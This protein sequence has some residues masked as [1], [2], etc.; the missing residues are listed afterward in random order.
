MTE[1]HSATP[2]ANDVLDQVAIWIERRDR[3]DWS[4]ADQAALDAWLEQSPAHLVAFLRSDNAW[5]RAD[6]LSALR[7]FPRND[8]P[9]DAGWKMM[10]TGRR[11]AALMAVLG[12]IG[13]AALTYTM[14]SS[15]QVYSTPV[16]GHTVLS[17]ADGSKI[18]LNTDTVLRVRNSGTQRLVKLDKGEA[19]FD[20][21]HDAA[22]PFVILAE[23][24]RVTDLGTKF[25]VH[26]GGNRLEVSLVEGSAQIKSMIPGEVSHVAVLT[27]GDVAIATANSMSVRKSSE[28]VLLQSLAWRRNVLILDNMTLAKAAAEFN[29]Y[30]KQKLVIADP[31]VARLTVVGTFHTNDVE[32][33]AEVAQDILHLHMKTDG[34][35]MEINR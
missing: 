11:I 21:K 12:G 7:T 9:P 20:I 10:I 31:V 8:V 17:L 28:K 13:A 23:N 1:T 16:G 6:R 34:D 32:G 3:E 5:K 26:D 2:N 35:R 24:H 33:F 15:E 29:R 27:K 4:A 14:P 22:H 25:V 30:N 19:F 18:E